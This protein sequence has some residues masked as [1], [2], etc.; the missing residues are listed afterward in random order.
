MNSSYHYL[1]MD[2]LAG[3]PGDPTSKSFPILGGGFLSS[4]LLF[5]IIGIILEV[6][7]PIWMQRKDNMDTKIKP[8]ML[9]WSGLLFG[10]NGAGFMVTLALTDMGRN[11]L[12][13]NPNNND[14]LLNVIRHSGYCYFLLKFL[15]FGRILFAVLR[16]R[17]HQSSL[18][19]FLQSSL[20]IWLIQS[21]VYF[22]P[23]GIVQFIAI[24]DTVLGCFT[25]SYYI[26][27]AAKYFDKKSWKKRLVLLQMTGYSLLVLHSAWFL[28]QP[29]CRQH[30]LVLYVQAMYGASSFLFFS[31]RYSNLIFSAESVDKSFK[32]M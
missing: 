22:R 6:V 19:C 27:A 1:S 25:N 20:I 18:F 24:I 8:L 26:L 16:K 14:L 28:I 30:V 32:S 9:I 13:C 23:D 10:I 4:G 5:L 12:N 17:N 7:L 11:T 15:D 31:I 3:F 21:V 2:S 29:S